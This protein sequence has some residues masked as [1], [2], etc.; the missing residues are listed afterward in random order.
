MASWHLIS[1]AGVRH[2]GGA[3]GVQ[4]LRLLPGG[5]APAATLARFPKLTED[6]Y[7]WVAEHR[8]RLSRLIPARAKCNARRRILERAGGL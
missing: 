3:A 1:P 7:R 6:A 8:S 4:A 5:R 2:S